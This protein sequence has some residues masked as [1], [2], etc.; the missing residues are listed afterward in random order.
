MPKTPR[1]LLR[2]DPRG[3]ARWRKASWPKRRSVNSSAGGWS[4]SLVID[5]KLGAVPVRE[6]GVDLESGSVVV[7]RLAEG[8]P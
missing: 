7:R 6:Q 8:T 5:E 3:T 1:A 2:S 4:T